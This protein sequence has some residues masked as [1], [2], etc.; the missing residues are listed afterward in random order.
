M[1]REKQQQE[2]ETV[3]EQLDVIEYDISCEDEKHEEE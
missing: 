3:L 1:P 2:I